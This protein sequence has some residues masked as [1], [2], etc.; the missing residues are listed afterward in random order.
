MIMNKW[1]IRD[2]AGIE[3]TDHGEFDSEDDAE[4]AL[5]EF[6]ESESDLNQDDDRQE[7]YI[8]EQVKP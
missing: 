5:Y 7:Y 2:W 4:M 3:L 8:E 1:I 6:I